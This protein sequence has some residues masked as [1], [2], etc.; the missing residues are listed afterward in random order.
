MCIRDSRDADVVAE[1]TRIAPGAVVLGSSDEGLTRSLGHLGCDVIVPTAPLG[2]FAAV[3]V[4][5]GGSTAEQAAQEMATRLALFADVPLLTDSR[6]SARTEKQLKALGVELE[7]GEVTG[8][9]LK[10][11]DSPTDDLV[12]HAGERD[13]IALLETLSGWT[14]TEPVILSSL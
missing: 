3:T 10:I 1:V 11:G 12:V 2:E 7:P 9:T 8:R 4:R 14:R 5:A 13:R 6:L